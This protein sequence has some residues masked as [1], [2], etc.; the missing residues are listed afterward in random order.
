MKIHKRQ[1][2]REQEIIINPVE[3][4]ITV[5]VNCDDKGKMNLNLNGKSVSGSEVKFN[6][7]IS[8]FVCD[9]QSQDC[10]HEKTNFMSLDGLLSHKRDAH[11]LK[12]GPNQCDLD[13]GHG[14]GHSH[15]PG[16]GHGTD[17]PGLG[18][19]GASSSCQPGEC[20]QIA[21]SSC[22]T[23]GLPC[24]S[25]CCECANKNLDQTGF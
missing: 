3:G 5:G 17:L 10:S 21:N 23:F 24:Q 9:S 14:N 18:P 13:H 4:T 25:E 15:G 19:A 1:A 7:Q 22:C 6:K 12:I 11:G 16:H 8:N 20:I 2:R